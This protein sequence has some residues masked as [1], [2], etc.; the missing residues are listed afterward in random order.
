M[1]LMRDFPVNDSPSISE[2]LK[3]IHARYDKLNSDRLVNV[4]SCVSRAEF[5]RV[6]SL[7]PIIL[8]SYLFKGIISNYDCYRQ[9]TDVNNGIVHFG[10][11]SKFNGYS[12]QNI[13]EGV[14]MACSSLI[15]DDGKAVYNAV[16]FYQ[17]FVMVHPFYDANGRIGRFIVEVYLNFYGIGIVW[18]KLCANTQWLKKLNNCHKRFNGREY[19]RYLDL[20]VAH[21]KKFV[22]D[23][24]NGL[25]I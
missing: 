7:L 19:D 16:K 15:I 23:V 18:K 10:P 2:T 20:L 22:F 25:D 14:R 17:Q 6:F 13:D 3:I 5:S 12:P 9:V 24:K 11:N 21:W 4:L 1:L 8:H